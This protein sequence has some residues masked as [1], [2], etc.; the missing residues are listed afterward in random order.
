[1]LLA[2]IPSTGGI[3]RARWH[4]N[5]ATSRER[6]WNDHPKTI[7]SVPS[8]PVGAPENEPSILRADST[9]VSS[10]STSSTHNRHHGPMVSAPPVSIQDTIQVTGASDPRSAPPSLPVVIIPKTTADRP[11]TVPEEQHAM[12]KTKQ[13]LSD[14]KPC[15]PSASWLSASIIHSTRVVRPPVLERQS[16]PMRSSSR[17]RSTR[18]GTDDMDEGDED[19]EDDPTHGGALSTAAA[20]VN[21]RQA[22]TTA[23]G[24]AIQKKPE[25]EEEK[26]HNSLERNRQFHDPSVE[27]PPAGPTP[28]TLSTRYQPPLV[29]AMYRGTAIV[30]STNAREPN[31]SRSGQGETHSAQ[32][33]ASEDAVRLRELLVWGDEESNFIVDFVIWVTESNFLRLQEL[34]PIVGDP[35]TNY[36]EAVDALGIRGQSI[37]TALIDHVDLEVFTCKICAHK[38]ENE[39]EDAITHQRVTH[40]RHYPY[41]CL[42]TQTQWYVSFLFLMGPYKDH[43]PVQW[44]AL[45]KPSGAGRTPTRDWA[46]GQD[47]NDIP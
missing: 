45:R 20:T 10:L 43:I 11:T 41:R 4:I 9:A 40:F 17:S 16:A 1:M 30:Y 7:H 6:Q 5:S 46:L 38:V 29:P 19:G 12:H 23:G 21:G 47:G 8:L 31:K 37:Y 15:Y 14:S 24:K 35:P 34:E 25:T 28:A 3:T 27:L 42:T 39:L 22:A 13:A 26:R 32:V 2:D 33:P 36:P 18:A 44:T